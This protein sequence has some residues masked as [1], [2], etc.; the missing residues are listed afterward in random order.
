MVYHIGLYERAKLRQQNDDILRGL[1]QLRTL[2]CIQN[3][4]GSVGP[5]KFENDF[6]LK[7]NLPDVAF[8]ETLTKINI[9]GNRISPHTKGSYAWVVEDAWKLPTKFSL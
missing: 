2:D 8:I 3:I 9:I 5:F 1:K 7:M 4:W 6:K